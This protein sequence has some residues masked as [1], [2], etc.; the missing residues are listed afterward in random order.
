MLRMLL[1]PGSGAPAGSGR[2]PAGVSDP[3]D[4][5]LA[6]ECGTGVTSEPL[7]Q[8]QTA[9]WAAVGLVAARRWT[10]RSLCLG[11]APPPPFVA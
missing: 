6:Q 9:A 11:V 4:P 1:S 5:V 2:A 10:G 7:L 3:P 8:A